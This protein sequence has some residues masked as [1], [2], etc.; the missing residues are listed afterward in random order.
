VVTV[1]KLQLEAWTDCRRRYP[2]V[3]DLRSV[4][5]SASTLSHPYARSRLLRMS[6]GGS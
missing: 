2:K 5:A 1:A 3:Q 6:S 4:G